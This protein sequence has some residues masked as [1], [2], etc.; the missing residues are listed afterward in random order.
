MNEEHKEKKCKLQQ[1]KEEYR[2]L[3]EES[4]ITSRSTF[5]EFSEKYGKDPRFK[6]VLKRKDQELFF[7]QFI[8]TLKKRD[9]EN[10]VRLRKMR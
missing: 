6:E 10:R 4:K 5:K 1:A 8:S 2:K 7:T 9:K 3:L